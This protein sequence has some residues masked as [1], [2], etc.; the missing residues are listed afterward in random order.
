MSYILRLS[1]LAQTQL[2]AQ[3]AILQVFIRANLDA[4]ALNPSALTRRGQNPFSQG[5]MA[6]FLFDH[7]GMT[8]WVTVQFLF[9]QDEESLHVERIGVEFGN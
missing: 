8:V 7:G 9:G 1:A 4:L 5:Q 3:P 6:E 2:A